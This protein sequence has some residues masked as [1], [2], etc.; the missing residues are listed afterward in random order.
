MGWIVNILRRIISHALRFAMASW[1]LIA[2]SQAGIREPQIRG[3]RGS[4]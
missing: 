1:K 3:R 4:S 2:W